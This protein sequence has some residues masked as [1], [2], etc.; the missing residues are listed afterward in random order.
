MARSTRRN[1]SL[2]NRCVKPGYAKITCGGV[3]GGADLFSKL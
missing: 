2:I 1:K 3:G